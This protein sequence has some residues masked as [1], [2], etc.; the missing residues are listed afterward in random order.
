ME[1]VIRH[2]VDEAERLEE[3]ANQILEECGAD[4]ERLSMLYD[5]LDELD[6]TGA[7]PRARK[8]LAGLG[9]N[10]RLVPMDRQTKAMSGEWRMRVSLA[11]ALFAQPTVSPHTAQVFRYVFLVQR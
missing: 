9:F 5:R 7:E 8:I 10:D 6:P 3:L 2:V 4:D 1:A 11:K